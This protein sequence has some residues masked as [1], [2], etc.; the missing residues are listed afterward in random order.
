MKTIILAGLVAVCGLAASMPN[1]SHAA[2]DVE[3]GAQVFRHCAACHSLEPDRHLTGPSLAGVWGR[4]AG[5]AAGFGRYSE[6]LKQAGITWDEKTLE[7][8]LKNP[9]ALI[10]GNQMIFAG[11]KHDAARQDLI[12]YLEATTTADVQA[13]RAETGQGN[14]MRGMSGGAPLDLKDAS[15]RQQVTAIRYCGDAYFVTL[16]TGDTF[17][18]WEFNVR[19]KTDSSKHGPPKGKPAIVRAGMMG[20]R[21]FVV[22]SGPEEISSFVTRRC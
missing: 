10:P 5:T 20:D 4:K 8:W 17:T 22:F 11:I 19:F 13:P 18:F 15:P 16:G 21:A 12:A 9:Q 1:W 2:G 3:K 7:A 6:A 14:M